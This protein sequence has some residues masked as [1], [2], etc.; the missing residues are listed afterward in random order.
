MT[1]L[2]AQFESDPALE[3]NGIWYDYGPFRAKI[4]YAGGANK[5]YQKF[6]E[7]VSKPFRRAIE[8]GS[9]PE[10]PNRASM[11]K[12]YA[13]TIIADWE[14]N[15]GE[16]NEAG[17]T[18]WTP[19]IEGRDGKIIPFNEANVL[20]TLEALPNLFIDFVTV[21][22]GSSNYRLADLEADGKNSKSS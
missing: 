1:G 9:F 6:L 3:Q 11:A 19:G 13:K 8:Q 2:Y 14:T 17:E 22:N 16:K 18:I 7:F 12:V 10:D 5:S 21:A 20:L 15:S 4:R